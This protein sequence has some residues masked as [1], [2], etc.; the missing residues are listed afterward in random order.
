M[1]KRKRD[2]DMAALEAAVT[3]TRLP[4]FVSGGTV[5]PD[6]AAHDAPDANGTA[7]AMPAGVCVCVCV[8]VLP[9]YFPRVF[10][11]LGSRWLPSQRV[12]QSAVR[13]AF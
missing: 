13:G 5:Q 1:G 9:L 12:L 3:H 6:Q 10:P 7:A 11:T 2:D 8:C 4:G